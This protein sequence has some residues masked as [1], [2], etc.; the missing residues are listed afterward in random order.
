[1]IVS[2]NDMDKF[3]EKEVK[4]IRS[5]KNTQYDCLINYIPDLITKIV[6]GFKD[7]VANFFKTNT[8]KQ[9]MYRSGKKQIQ[10]HQKSF[11]IKKI[12]KKQKKKIKLGQLQIE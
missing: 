9:I 4:K 5:F 6:G 7:K 12:K 3:D 8:P 10:Q 1:M 11:Y 2:V